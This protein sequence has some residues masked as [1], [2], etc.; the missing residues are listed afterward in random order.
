MRPVASSSIADRM[1]RRIR[2]EDGTT[3]PPW[4]LWMPSVSTSTRTVAT[5]FPR[6]DVVSHSRS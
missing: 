1:R 3:P 6:S 5:R 2:N 4:P